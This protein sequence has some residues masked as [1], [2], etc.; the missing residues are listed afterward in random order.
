MTL[1]K[2]L[3]YAHVVVGTVGLVTFW[4]PIIGKKGGAAHKR[5][6]VIFANALLSTGI[7]AIGI[8]VTTLIWPLETHTFWTDAARIRG[9]FGWMML[10]LAVLTVTLSLYGRW[11]IQNRQNHRAN[12][13][14]LNLALQAAMFLLAL[15]CA[16]RGIALGEPVMMGVSVVGLAAAILNTRFILTD[17]PAHKEWL[18][19][20]TRGL[21]GA[22]ISVYTAFL[23]FGAVNLL[24]KFAFNPI[25]WATPTVLGVIYLLYH[26]ALIILERRRADSARAM[27]RATRPDQ[28]PASAS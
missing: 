18:V 6:G 8:S 12:R 26:Q 20:H 27:R 23:A 17:R 9:L 14:P 5:W 7:I 1:F 2:A 16:G 4:V 3:I 22:G 21:V 19:Q 28:Q 25:L 11:T 10:Y 13:T 24:P 15:N